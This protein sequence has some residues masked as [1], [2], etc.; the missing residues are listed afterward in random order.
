MN[1]NNCPIC[2]ETLEV[3]ETTPC[4]CCGNDEDKISILKQDIDEG[5]RHDSNTFSIYRAF[6]EIECVLCDL[7]IYEFSAV[8]PEFFGFHKEKTIWPDNFQYLKSIE[9]PY[10]EKDKFC[11]SCFMRLSFLNFTVK[12]R[13]K[14]GA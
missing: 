1:I 10:I 14:N 4:M 5:F 11:K 8:N 6:G 13:A 7:C 12:L 3:I 2:Y 9:P